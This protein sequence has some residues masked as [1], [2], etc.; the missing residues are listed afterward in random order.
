MLH[1]LLMQVMKQRLI[2]RHAIAGRRD[3]GIMATRCEKMKMPLSR[4]GQMMLQ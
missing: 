1:C 4:A 2:M 3:A